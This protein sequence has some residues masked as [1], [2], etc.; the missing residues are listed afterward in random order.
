MSCQAVPVFPWSTPACSVKMEAG[1][2]DTCEHPFLSEQFVG[3]EASSPLIPQ[4]CGGHSRV[5]QAWLEA[6]AA[7]A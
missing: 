2:Y 4:L 7:Q 6:P 5:T 3:E 1:L